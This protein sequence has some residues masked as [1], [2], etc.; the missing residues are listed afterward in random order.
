MKLAH[1]DAYSKGTAWRSLIALYQT[2]KRFKQ[3]WSEFYQLAQKAGMED[4]QTLE[5]LKDWLSTELKDRLVNI[6]E[7]DI[8][9][10][11]FVKKVQ[12][13]ATKLEV[14][15]KISNSRFL[16]T[17]NRSNQPNSNSNA[18]SKPTYKATSSA[19]AV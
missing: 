12:R 19:P 15:S 5:Y 17:G 6:D 2:N 11:I 3:F 8:D 1:G 16:A 4:A 10:A 14:L 9:L 18:N 13:I 7:T